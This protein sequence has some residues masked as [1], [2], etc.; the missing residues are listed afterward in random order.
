MHIAEGFVQQAQHHPEKPAVLIWQEAQQPISGCY[1]ELLDAVQQVAATIAAFDRSVRSDRKRLLDSTPLLPSTPLQ[2][3][4]CVGLLLP[5]CLEFLEIFLGVAMVGGVS[6]VL[7]PQWPSAQIHQVLQDYPIDLLFVEATLL[8]HLTELPTALK[9]VRLTP[10]FFKGDRGNKGEQ[11]QSDRCSNYTQWRN[12][13][14]GDPGSMRPIAESDPFYVGFTSGTTATAK[15]VIRSHRSWL[16]SFS[17]SHIEFGTQAADRILVPGSLVHSLSLYAALESLNAGATLYLL[18]QF[19]AKA[20]STCLQTHAITT[21]I[22]VPTL[23]KSIA[24]AAT[25]Y[26]Q[27]NGEQTGSEQTG[28]EQNYS[29]LRSV[30]AGGSKL[31][32]DLRTTLPHVF[33]KADILEYFGALELSFICLASSRESVPPKSVGRAFK[34]VTVSIQRLDGRGEAEVGEVGWIGVK[35]PMLSSGYF[36]AENAAGYRVVDGWATVGDRGWRDANGYFYLVG[37]EQEMLVSGG[38]NVY[39]AEI[40]AALRGFPEVDE[41]AVFGVPDADR[42]QAIAAAIRWTGQPLSRSELQQRLRGILPLPKCPRHW[43][44][45]DDFPRTHSGKII[46]A[47]L[48]E[49]ILANKLIVKSGYSN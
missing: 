41:V 34:G 43:F 12:S 11:V 30:I 21:L 6:I 20:A 29:S 36:K 15:G 47:A 7:D 35:S 45:I 33:A 1:G 48:R 26:K 13:H 5:N 32:P 9:T 2:H 44:A 39:P 25:R 18:P 16:N 14:P 17:A 38:V 8:P 4:V 23:L 10:C 28:S 19:S 46:R 24:K 31:E 40:E 3:Y 22:A 37:R 42:G 49:Q 27:V